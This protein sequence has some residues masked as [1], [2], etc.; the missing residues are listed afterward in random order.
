MYETIRRVTLQLH[1]AGP[2]EDRRLARRWKLVHELDALLQLLGPLRGRT[3][4]DEVNAS[5]QPG[6]GDARAQ[7]P[8]R[9]PS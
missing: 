5:F 2:P 8:K 9:L 3:R 7:R 1:R 4:S 6:H